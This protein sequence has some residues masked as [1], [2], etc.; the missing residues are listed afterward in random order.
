MYTSLNMKLRRMIRS[1]FFRLFGRLIVESRFRRRTREHEKLNKEKSKIEFAFRR[2]ESS[3]QDIQYP[4]NEFNKI[5]SMLL[6]DL[7][8][9]ELI[10]QR[11]RRERSLLS[12]ISRE[13]QFLLHHL[14]PDRRS[15]PSHP[16]SKINNQAIKVDVQALFIFGMIMVNRLSL[17]LKMYLSDRA[18]VSSKDMYSKIGLFYSELNKIPNPSQLAQRFKNRFLLKLKWLYAALR[19]YRNEFIEHLDKGYQQGMNYGTYTSTFALTSYKWDYDDEDD[20]KIEQFKAKLEKLNIKISGR[21][22]GGR[23]LNNRYYVQ[24]LFDN[25]TKVPD[26]LLN[27]A[28]D[29]IEDIGV[30]SPQPEK[31]IKEIEEYVG[32]V[33]DFMTEE[34]DASELNKFKKT[35]SL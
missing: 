27:D 24:M 6:A 13:D 31:V 3:L 21:D 14:D 15:Y 10:V 9:F 5:M 11:F 29:L 28:L 17:L 25:I 2:F 7:E 4:N 32:G 22:D 16:L 8:S 34:L 12:H 30:H 1:L 23:S 20:E 35:K 33:L 26:S 19:F 18:S